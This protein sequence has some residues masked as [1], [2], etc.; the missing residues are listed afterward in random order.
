MSILLMYV[1]IFDKKKKKTKYDL[2]SKIQ[3]LYAFFLPT[4][5][6]ETENVTKYLKTN[7]A[8]GKV[9]INTKNL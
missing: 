7:Q 9:E 1:K 6:Q 8:S 5:E 4:Y 3:Q 2:E